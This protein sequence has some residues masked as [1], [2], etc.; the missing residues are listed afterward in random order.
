MSEADLKSYKFLSGEEPSDEQLQAI[1]EAA[2][3]EVLRRAEEAH[4]RFENQFDTLYA[5]EYARIS[6]RIE[7][8]RSGEF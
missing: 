4:T 6:Q 7:K 2:L 1:M 5:Q 3:T 8:A